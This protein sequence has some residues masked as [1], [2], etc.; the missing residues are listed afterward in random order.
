MTTY[1][2]KLKSGMELIVFSYGY[3]DAILDTIE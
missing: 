3:Y 1:H 2:K